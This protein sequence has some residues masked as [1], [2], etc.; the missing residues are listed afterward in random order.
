[1]SMG[2]ASDNTTPCYQLTPAE[3]QR[4]GAGA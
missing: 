1:M 3:T 4:V 2:C